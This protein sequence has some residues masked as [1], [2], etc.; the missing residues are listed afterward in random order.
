M[1]SIRRIGCGY[2]LLQPGVLC[3]QVRLSGACH[4]LCLQAKRLSTIAAVTLQQQLLREAL[5]QLRVSC[6]MLLRS[7]TLLSALARHYVSIASAC[8]QPCC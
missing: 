3:L 4:R 7:M 5:G 6:N 2:L 8:T 1:I